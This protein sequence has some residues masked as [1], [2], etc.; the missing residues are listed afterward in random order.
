MPL[1]LVRILNKT[2]GLIIAHYGLI[3][4]TFTHSL[5]LCCSYTMRPSHKTIAKLNTSQT[6][7]THTSS[8]RN[9]RVRVTR[10][11]LPRWSLNSLS[12]SLV[13]WA[14]GSTGHTEEDNPN[15]LQYSS[16]R[17]VTNYQNINTYIRVYLFIL[18]ILV[19][20]VWCFIP[21]YHM[22]YYACRL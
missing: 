14:L 6:E 2:I 8:W 5:T 9:T 12:C 10:W 16:G 22:H 21:M 20:T 15:R 19:V 7:P 1:T 3:A 17:L 13:H 11:N 18:S 4:I